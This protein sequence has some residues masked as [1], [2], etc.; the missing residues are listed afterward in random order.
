[1]ALST[2]P[3]AKKRFEVLEVLVVGAEERFD[4]CFGNGD[5]FQ[6]SISLPY[7]HLATDYTPLR[8]WP[9]VQFP[10]LFSVDG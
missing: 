7:R 9:Q 6:S 10:Q 2:D 4:S 5:A 3:D 8:L 1:M